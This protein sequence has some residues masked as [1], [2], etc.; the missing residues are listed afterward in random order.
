LAL[1][2]GRYQVANNT[3]AENYAWFHGGGIQAGNSA[4]VTLTNNLFYQ[5]ES[6][7]EWACYQMNR[8]ADADGG[9]NMQYPEYRYNQSGSV[10]DCLV[11]PTAIMDDPELQPLGNNGGP[12]LTMAL[13]ESSAAVGAGNSAGAPQLDQRGYERINPIDSGAFQYNSRPPFGLVDVISILQIC[14]GMM[15]DTTELQVMDIDDDSR[16]GVEEAIFALQSIAG[17][18]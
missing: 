8:E 9:G 3:F 18:Q 1:S 15:P 6:E 12:T 14:A 2:A 16:L 4:D 7:R 5:N 10:I 13:L 17:G 11:T